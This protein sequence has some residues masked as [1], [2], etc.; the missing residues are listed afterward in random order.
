M[1]E[2]VDILIIGGGVMGT[3]IAYHLAQRQLGKIL[4]LEKDSLASGSTGHSVA[5]IDLLTFRP[6]ATELYAR[7]FKFFQ[8][9]KETLGEGCGF[10]QTGSLII[11]GKEEKIAL[12]DAVERGQRTGLKV[13]L[14]N[15]FA[16]FNALEPS[17]TSEKIA[18]VSYAPQ[19]GYADPVL[20]TQAFAKAAQ[21]MGVDIQSGRKVIGLRN[22]GGRITGVETERGFIPA[23]VIIIAAGPWSGRLLTPLGIKIGF[24]TVRHP[25][26]C[27]RRPDDFGTAHYSILD[28]VN[29]IYARPDNGSLSLFG[30]IDTNVGYDPVD[31]DDNHGGVPNEYTLWAAERLVR[32]YPK[33][34]TSALRKGWSGIL[35]ISPDWQPVIG[36]VEDFSS[37]Y[38]A[39]GFSG[40]GFQISPAVG[41]L[42]AGQIA[43]EYEAIQL[44]TPFRPS[45]FVDGQRISFSHESISLGLSG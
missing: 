21:Q 39:T 32:R 42:L 15:S 3:S 20:T 24:Q 44:L 13:E 43:G 18:A 30:S 2:S 34:E 36:A 23:S 12:R 25:V 11:A 17:A 40:Q 1:T 14:L 33:L 5:S 10:T 7:S 8:N 4:L 22:K 19:A 27:L 45:R 29:G 6:P 16:E 37:L 26:A 38:C 9:F 35:T 28:L 41:D 31:P